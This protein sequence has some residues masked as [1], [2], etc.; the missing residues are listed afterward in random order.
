MALAPSQKQ[1]IG[2][3]QMQGTILSTTS[4]IF[5]AMASESDIS[6]GAGLKQISESVQFLCILRWDVR[7]ILTLQH[8]QQ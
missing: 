3:I 1:S 7:E 2:V 6:G 4:L 5:D 8:I